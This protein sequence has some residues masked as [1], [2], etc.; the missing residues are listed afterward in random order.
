MPAKRGDDRLTQLV[1][2]IA[3][4]ASGDL[5]T[6]IAVSQ[7]RDEIDAV[8]M[9]INLLAEELQLMYKQLEQRVEERTA[10]LRRA[11][12]AMSLMAMT[13]ALTGLANRAALAERINEALER[14]PDGRRTPALLLLD[15]NSFKQINDSFGHEAGD[16]VLVAVGQR[17]REAV[18]EG[19]TVAR[20]GGDEFAI[21]IPEATVDQALATANRILA[22]LGRSI[23]LDEMN[24]WPQA[25][26]GLCVAEPGQTAQELLLEADTAMYEAKKD[27]RA[28]IKMFQPPMLFSRQL[29][30]QM[31][32]EL[33][34][35]IAAGEFTLYYQ[36]VVELATGRIRGAEVLVRWNH[37]ER[38]MVMPDEFIPLAEET[39]LIIDLGRWI[40]RTAVLAFARWRTVIPLED[41]FRLRVNLSVAELQRIDLVDYVR[42][43]LRDSRIDPAQLVLEITETALVTGGDVETYSLLSLKSLGVDIEIDDF[44]TGYSSISYLRTLPVSMVKVD[45]SILAGTNGDISRNE[46]IA[47][48]LQLIRAAGLEAVFEG[49]ET[50]EQVDRLLAMGCTSGQGYYFSRP[51]PESELLELLGNSV[52]LPAPA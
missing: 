10:M 51:V 39:G 13:D 49:I 4:L 50:K 36:P 5:S 47:A 35:A 46:F 22:V 24:V 19:D 16:R 48:V 11:H 40:M 45:R 27:R 26:I 44:G 33:R 18:R 3:R 15:L 30:N 20:L 2:A 38:G 42:E 23:Q 1:D 34:D 52:S 37:P 43:V 25:S 9:G 31:A 14:T 29:H 28:S 41:D 7:E 6:R 32:A 17:L 8:S 12:Q 21:L